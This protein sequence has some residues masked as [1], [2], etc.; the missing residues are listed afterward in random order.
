M[1]ELA[2]NETVK[3]RLSTCRKCPLVTA[4]LGFMTCGTFGVKRKKTCG[5]IIKAKA[6]F[7]NQSCPSG[8]W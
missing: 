1:F 8:K 2:D 3:A 7:I 5:C 6:Q 4:H